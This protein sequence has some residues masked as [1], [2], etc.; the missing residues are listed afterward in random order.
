MPLPPLPTN[1]QWSHDV[2]TSTR[3]LFDIY[4]NTKNALKQQPDR[5]RVLTHTG[6]IMET[7][8]PLLDALADSP[9]NIPTVWLESCTR[10]FGV[11]IAHLQAAE[12][13]ADGQ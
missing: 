7:A 9:D 11:L 6:L 1:Q 3:I 2:V 13:E 8:L 5:H 4:E 10:K 12:Q